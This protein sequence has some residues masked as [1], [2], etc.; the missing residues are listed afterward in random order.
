M[1]LSLKIY[2]IE[3]AVWSWDLQIAAL[4]SFCSFTYLFLS[5][6]FNKLKSHL[7]LTGR[8]RRPKKGKPFSKVFGESLHAN[9]FYLRRKLPLVMPL[10]TP[11]KSAFGVAVFPFA[12]LF[13]VMK[14]TRNQEARHKLAV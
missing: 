5:C 13:P 11:E 7:L 6:Y 4:Y 10:T 12:F 8:E 2:R 3:T 1:G 9:V 14:L